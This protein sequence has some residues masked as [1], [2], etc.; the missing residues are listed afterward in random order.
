MC[1]ISSYLKEKSSLWFNRVRLGTATNLRDGPLVAQ[2]CILSVSGKMLA[3]C[4]EKVWGGTE[5]SLESRLGPRNRL[6][7]A[8]QRWSA[9]FRLIPARRVWTSSDRFVVSRVG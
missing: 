9:A 4:L 5:L 2:N 8:L 3:R 1:H 7:P 6:K